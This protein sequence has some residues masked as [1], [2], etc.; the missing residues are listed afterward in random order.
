MT[1]FI[2]APAIFRH[3]QPLALE[4]MQGLTI[5]GYNG[6]FRNLVKDSG[7]DPDSP[8]IGIGVE[9]NQVGEILGTRLLLCGKIPETKIS[10]ADLFPEAEEHGKVVFQK[11]DIGNWTMPNGL[12]TSHWTRREDNSVNWFINM[13]SGGRSKTIRFPKHAE[14]GFGDVSFRLN[15]QPTSVSQMK[16]SLGVAPVGGEDLE[17]MHCWTSRKFPT[18][19][20]QNIRANIFPK[21]E[22]GQNLGL[23]FQP[24]FILRGTEP[25]NVDM[26]AVNYPTSMSVKE[27][28]VLML[29]GSTKPNE[30]VNAKKWKDAIDNGE[31]LAEKTTILWPSP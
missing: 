27:A 18:V 24:I 31:L 6:A 25:G 3:H 14:Y 8:W 29:Q 21:E 20:L 1:K 16:V 11:T 22:P 19:A 2:E 7:E 13:Q 23:G 15:I 26:E 9:I 4:N 10:T 12:L 28:T 5:Y 30:R 17:K